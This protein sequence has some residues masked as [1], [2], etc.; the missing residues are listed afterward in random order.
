MKTFL[1]PSEKEELFFRAAHLKELS[2]DT[3]K[4]NLA[5]T[6]LLKVKD[7]NYLEIKKESPNIKHPFSVIVYDNDNTEN[8]PFK[9]RKNAQDFIDTLNFINN[10][11]K[12]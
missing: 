4:I 2:L 6:F 7:K 1:D 9:T 12:N 3:D 5:C 11:S 8:A 10:L